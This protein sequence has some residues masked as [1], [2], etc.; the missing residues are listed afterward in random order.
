MDKKDLIAISAGKTPA[1]LVLKNA[2]VINVFSEEVIKSDIA[3]AE[4]FIVGIGQYQG[5]NEIDLAG[6]YVC[7]GFIDGHMHL[8]SSLL[9]PDEFEKAVLPRGTTAVVADPHEIANVSGTTG[10]D[11]MRA[12]TKQLSMHTF[13]TLPSCVPSGPLDEPGATLK[14]MDLKPYYRKN[15]VVGLAEVMD[16]PGVISCDSD[17]LQKIADAY[18]ANRLVDGH[19][20]GLSGKELNA[21][22]ASGILSDHEC[23]T[24]EEAMERLRLGQW[25]MVREGT[26]AKNL[27]A[28]LPVCKPPF[29]H[30]A[31]FVTDD[32]HPED[33]THLGHIDAVIRKAISHGVDPIHAIVMATINPASYFRLPHLGAVAPGYKADLVVLSD[34]ISVAVDEVYVD[35]VKVAKKGVMIH[36]STYEVTPPPSILHSFHMKPV[37]PCDFRL[38]PLGDKVRVIQMHP[39]ELLTS[40]E[41]MDTSTALSSDEVAKIAVIERHHHLDHIGLGLL[42]GYGLKKGAVATSVAHDTHNLIVVGQNDD[43]MAIAA[44]RALEIQGGLILVN[45]GKVLSELPLTIAGLMSPLPMEDVTKRL[46]TLKEHALSLGISEDIDPFMT[47]AFMSLPV[48]PKLKINSRGLIDVEKQQ[49]VDISIV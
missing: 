7:P 6:K 39:H 23:S 40:E 1:P 24:K 34:L 48:I 27:E 16:A 2:S 8:E 30:R 21:Y 3:I 13:F 9:R 14:A 42:K 41:I 5:D 37:H 49:I 35:G 25:I 19:A 45:D 12:V 18:E 32:R 33:L 20:P 28:L 47:L 10:I 31:M 43:D 17:L 22:I 26:A 11:Y 29:Y 38:P 15:N 44:N 46:V 36:P 4:G